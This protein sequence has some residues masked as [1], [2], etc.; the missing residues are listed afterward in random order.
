MFISVIIALLG[1]VPSVFVTGANI[2][3]FGPIN[4]FL[5]S[6][7]GEVIGGWISF[8]VYRKGIKRFAGNIEGKY[9]LIDK[10]VKSEGRSVGILIFEGRLIPFIPSGLVT[11]AAAMSKVNSLIFIIATFL[12][13]IPSILLEVLASYGVILAYQKN[14]KLVI[15]IFSLIL[16]FLTVKRIRGN[17][18]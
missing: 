6:L 16:L 3:F 18:G 9:E 11:L 12:G 8:K 17:R 14:I 7:L 13:K 1:I 5:I 2:V 10:I 4:G 15:G